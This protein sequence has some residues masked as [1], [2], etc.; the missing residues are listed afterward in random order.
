MASCAS[1]KPSAPARAR[2]SAIAEAGARR[3][4]IWDLFSAWARAVGCPRMLAGPRPSAA[5]HSVRRAG[6][7]FAEMPRQVLG[8]IPPAETV[9]QRLKCCNGLL[10]ERSP[11]SGRPVASVFFGKHALA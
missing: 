8:Q 4:R 1:L 10:P 7:D 9:P 11:S 6:W 5:D 3:R 2:S